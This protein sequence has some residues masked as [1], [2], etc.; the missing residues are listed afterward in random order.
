MTILFLQQP[1]LGS[2]ECFI[3][4]LETVSAPPGKGHPLKT[5]TPHSVTGG[6]DVFV[7]GL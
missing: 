5:K 6:G 4:T 3:G 1:T 2:K 7:F